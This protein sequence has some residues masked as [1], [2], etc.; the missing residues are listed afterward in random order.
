MEVP[1]LFKFTKGGKTYY[2]F[3]GERTCS[4]CNKEITDPIGIIYYFWHTKKSSRKVLHANCNKELNK[5]KEVNTISEQY[6]VLFSVEVPDSAI[7]VFISPPTLKQGRVKD[8]FAVADLDSD[9]TVDKTRYAGRLGSIKGASVGLSQDK[10]ALLL[11]K[12][13]IEQEAEK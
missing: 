7:P 4:F 9:K 10:R 13:I 3:T 8:V 5:I 12:E 6:N 1:D 11:D 2:F